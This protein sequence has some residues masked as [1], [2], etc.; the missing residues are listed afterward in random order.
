MNSKD[1]G[2]TYNIQL[3]K[4]MERGRKRKEKENGLLNQ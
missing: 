2:Q 4:K 1:L 3:Y